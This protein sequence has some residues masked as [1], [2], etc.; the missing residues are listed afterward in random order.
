LHFGAGTPGVLIL[1]IT[2]ILT[3]IGSGAGVSPPGES[4]RHE[5]SVVEINLV[6]STIMTLDTPSEKECDSIAFICKGLAVSPI[7]HYVCQC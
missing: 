1:R 2:E 5:G 6:N 7:W 3:R 4:E